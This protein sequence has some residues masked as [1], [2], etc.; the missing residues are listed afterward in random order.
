MDNIALTH[1]SGKGERS[2]FGVLSGNP[3]SPKLH[4]MNIE[5]INRFWGVR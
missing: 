2:V 4:E 5:P 3:E 1:F